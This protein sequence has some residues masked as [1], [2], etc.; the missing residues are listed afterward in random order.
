MN[1][2]LAEPNQIASPL[3]RFPQD[4]AFSRLDESDDMLF[5]AK[6][7]FVHHLDAVA[8]STVEKV[9]GELLNEESPIILDLMASWDSHLPARLEAARVVGLGLNRKELEENK[10]LSEIVIHDL[11]ANPL[12]PFP[13]AIFDAVINT[14]SVDYMTRP[15]EVFREVGRVLKPGGVFLVIFSNR[16]FPE[17]ATKLWQI[18]SEAERIAIVEEFFR[19]A[20]SFDEPRVFASRGRPRPEDDRYAHLGIPSDPI[21]AVYADRLGAPTGRRPRPELEAS[22]QDCRSAETVSEKRGAIKDTLQCP[23]C[24]QRMRKW[25]PPNSPFSTWDTEYMYICFNDECPY[26][27]RG[28]GVMDRQ[29]NRVMSYRVMYDP[30]RDSCLTIPI[31]SLHAL[32]EGIVD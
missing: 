14:V 1:T 5:Y 16:M 27:V 9:I 30:Q 15:V 21:Y 20:K 10:R 4:E 8:L 3:H 19:S 13:D 17:K 2:A 24:G 18:S 26:V 31:I 32:K 12:L 23:H 6:D 7:R 25:E 28:W 11:N 29:G 22:D